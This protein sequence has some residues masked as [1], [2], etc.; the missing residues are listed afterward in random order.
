[1]TPRYLPPGHQ[2]SAAPWIVMALLWLCTV[3][4]YV[5]QQDAADAA[6]AERLS[7]ARS[8]QKHADRIERAANAVCT[9]SHGPG[10]AHWWDGSVLVCARATRDLEVA[11]K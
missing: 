4:G 7:A 6:Q 8:A 9:E 11:S 2:P 5:M 3:Y 1:M 10:A